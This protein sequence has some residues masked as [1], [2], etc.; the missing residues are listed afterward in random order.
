MH[1]GHTGRQGLHQGRVPRRQLEA[2]HH[3]GGSEIKPN[4][5][6]I[7]EAETEFDDKGA[8]NFEVELGLA[9]GDRAKIMAGIT[10]ACEDTT[11]YVQ[12]WRR[13]WYQLTV[14]EGEDEPDLSQ[15]ADALGKVFI[16]YLKEGETK[17]IPKGAGPEGIC[18]W[19]DGSYFADR[20]G[21]SPGE[22]V[23]NIGKHNREHFHGLF[24]PVHT[25][26][27]VHVLC[28]R[29][30]F[31]ARNNAKR[32]KQYLR[33]PV[34]LDTKVT[35]SDG[36]QVVGLRKGVDAGFYP[37]K[38]YDGSH[39]LMAGRWKASDKSAQG[40]ITEDD[41][42]IKNH[43]ITVK[44]PDD[45]L[46][47]LN[48]VGEGEAPRTVKVSIRVWTA[49]GPLNGNSQGHLQLL[50]IG[51]D[52]KGICQTL[53]HELGHSLRQVANTSSRKSPG[54]TGLPHGREYTDNGHSGAHCAEGMSADNY[55]GGAGK[56]GTRYQGNFRGKSECKC[57]MYGEGS[58]TRAND[59][60][61]R[62]KPFI[63]A[64]AAQSV[65]R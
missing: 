63:V 44:L 25:P 56:A 57:V 26:L 13:I 35:W 53:C 47:Y 15:S 29:V 7:A 55:A 40:D 51:R 18:S 38:L 46:E 41:T 42:F 32:R 4:D 10:K 11:L 48:G 34:T 27:H 54:L 58:P 19:V 14:P 23:S 52:D 64:E 49:D 33:M 22:L 62:C 39:P 24:E 1:R 21:T 2:E 16:E 65:V 9:G 31:D 61:E 60:C 6:G 30:V 37:T 8:A 3:V 5:K 20:Y 45:A 59:F 17:T 12:N 43:R 28:S 50:R 36:S